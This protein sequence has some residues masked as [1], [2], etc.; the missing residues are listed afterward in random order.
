MRAIARLGRFIRKTLVRPTMSFVPAVV[1]STVTFG[2][3]VPAVSLARSGLV[4]SGLVKTG[5]VMLALAGLPMTK[6]S[7]DPLPMPTIAAVA[8]VSVVNTNANASASAVK[9][10]ADADSA[11]P[12]PPAFCQSKPLVIAHRGASGYLPE[13]S[14]A[15]YLKA[16]EQGADIIE[17][18]LVPTRDGILISR[19]ENE[20]NLSTD[21][22][23]RAEFADRKTRKQVDGI[24]Q[25]GWFSEDF[26]LAELKTLGLNETRPELRP[27]SAKYNG[28]FQIVTLTEIIQRLH[29]VNQL[30]AAQPGLAPVGLYLETKHPTYF[31][32]AGVSL[33]GQPIAQDITQ[34]LLQTLEQSVELL[35]NVVYIQ[36]FEISNLANIRF[37]YW[38]QLTKQLQQRLQ[39]IQLIGD[40][41]GRFLQPND[42]FSEPFDQVFAKQHPTAQPLPE[43]VQT[44][45]AALG[46]PSVHYGELTSTQGLTMIA[47]YAD[48]IGPWRENLYPQIG[49]DLSMLRQA[50]Q[51]GLKVHP[52]TFRAEAPYLLK[53]QQG[54]PQS[55]HDELYWLFR[56]GIDGVFADFP[57]IAV[58]AKNAACSQS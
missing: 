49:S 5:L 16:I 38:P 19:H 12:N 39:L 29:Q 24:W 6:A 4:K 2:L 11:V 31:S 56:Q 8:A 14:M 34:L 1:S 3:A 51:L 41:S 23:S 35:P 46:G 55:M 44:A 43:S 26:T 10:L 13:H 33:S 36:S 52:Y 37:Q 45:L 7:A 22:A 40:T 21:V 9:Q 50:Q 28:K 58:A 48:G 57:D 17:A 42:S 54:V 18:D 25:E 47:S 27:E 15:A 53:N 32:H 30:R 20:L